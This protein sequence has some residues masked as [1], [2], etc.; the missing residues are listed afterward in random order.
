[1]E[2]VEKGTKSPKMVGKKLETTLASLQ[3]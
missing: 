2:V 1:M 3:I